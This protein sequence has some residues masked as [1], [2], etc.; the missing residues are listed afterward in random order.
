M[1]D[2]ARAARRL[3]IWRGISSRLTAARGAMTQRELGR[4]SGI[5]AA[6]I[7]RYETAEVTPSA[8]ALHALGDALGVDPAWLLTGEGNGP[9]EAA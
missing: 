7:S 3:E 6:T 4:R 8:A 5:A 9:A 1:D 2:D